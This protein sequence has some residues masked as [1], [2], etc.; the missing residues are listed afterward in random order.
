MYTVSWNSYLLFLSL[1]FCRVWCSDAGNAATIDVRT[2]GA[3]W[4]ELTDD[5]RKPYTDRAEHLKAQGH[6]LQQASST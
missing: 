5:E 2:L 3:M 4:R 1:T 6:T